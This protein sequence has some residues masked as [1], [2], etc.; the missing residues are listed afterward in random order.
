MLPA[1]LGRV[2]VLEPDVDVL[3]STATVRLDPAQSDLPGTSNL[4]SC[5]DGRVGRTEH[6]NG[7]GRNR[8]GRTPFG[9]LADFRRHVTTELH[10][11][12]CL[13][14]VGWQRLRL[15]VRELHL[16]LLHRATVTVTG[17]PI[18]L[19]SALGVIS[20]CS[21]L[22]D[23]RIRHREGFAEWYGFGAQG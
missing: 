17:L 11:E 14:L 22:G 1:A 8:V 12:R 23:T 20:R 19:Y 3:E 5:S 4:R 6:T 21:S 16:I 2:K 13:L 9:N 7:V 10:F 18:D 15:P